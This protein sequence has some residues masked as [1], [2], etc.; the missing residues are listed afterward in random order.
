MRS[1]ELALIAIAACGGQRG[2][3]KI[4][5]EEQTVYHTHGGPGAMVSSFTLRVTNGSRAAHTVAVGTLE[6]L[7][8]S[9]S[10]REWK[11][12]QPLPVL[13]P[14]A[15][16]PIAPGADA[17]LTLTF[18]AVEVYQAYDRFGFRVKLT[19]DGAPREIVTDLDVER[20]EPLP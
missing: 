11:S 10:E 17:R 3:L 20:E 9:P 1:A 19:V 8:G 12:A 4:V 16:V 18:D 14:S 5:G 7:H 2:V 15:P 6:L 13:E